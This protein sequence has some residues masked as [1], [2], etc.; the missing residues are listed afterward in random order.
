VH[1]SSLA[2]LAV[3]SLA[4]CS[5]GQAQTFVDPEHLEAA[6]K[7]FNSTAAAGT[8]QCDV[9]PIPPALD[10]RLHLQAGYKI[11]IPLNQF[12]GTGH[13]WSVLLRVTPAGGEPVY[14]STTSHLPVVPDNRADG[15]V[16]GGF[17][18]GE[19]GYDVTALARDDLHRSCR[20][21]WH[22]DAKLNGAER[23]LK[24]LTPP[25]TVAEISGVSSQ[26]PASAASTIGR[27]T[28][29]L[30]AL[31]FKPHSADPD[32]VD[33]SM[34]AGMLEALLEQLPAREVRFAMFNL[35][36]QRVLLHSD[37]FTAGSI[38]G[39]SQ[40]ID[41]LQLAKVD[42]SV[43]KNRTGAV[44][45]LTS[46][47]DKELHRETPS[48]VVVFLG[49][50]SRTDDAIPAQAFERES[51]PATQ[52]FYLQCI[53]PR[54]DLAQQQRSPFERRGMRGGGLQG[55]PVYTM[56]RRLPDSIEHLMKRLKG[57]TIELARPRDFAGA[58]TLLS[59]AAQH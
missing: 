42:Y 14:L 31:P 44:D 33:N 40:A 23:S 48:D 54:V 16:T 53:V 17:V 11:S 1:L 38:E 59:H 36:Q 9:K 26:S 41:A 5:A 22:V 3:I 8:L 19:G 37:S 18:V 7:A 28:I 39:V 51:H 25:H 10:F 24:S 45:L 35:E 47:V 13:G 57:R 58:V 30:H 52:F 55:P 29:L 21:T 43:L 27:L 15:E 2:K 12:H 46:L 50:H 32:E 56:R 20:S 6:K 4:L 34:L 49:P